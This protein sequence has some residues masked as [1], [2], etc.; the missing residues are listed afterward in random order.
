MTHPQNNIV[1]MPT[2]VAD[3]QIQGGTVSGQNCPTVVFCS[4]IVLNSYT[5]LVLL[6]IKGLISKLY[7]I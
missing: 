5:S 2:V 1:A 4:G 6:R 3:H 7:A